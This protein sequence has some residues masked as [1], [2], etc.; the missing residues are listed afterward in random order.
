M[1]C[2]RA[3][4]VA[5]PST[6][7]GCVIMRRPRSYILSVTL[8]LIVFAGIGGAEPKERKERARQLSFKVVAVYPHDY[9]AFTEGLE[10]RDGFLLESTGLMGES[11]LR[12]VDLTTG[13]VVSKIALEPHLFGEGCTALRD[14][15][16]LVTWRNRIG[17]VYDF[18][19]WNIVR[20]FS[21]QGEG[22][23]LAND[24]RRIFMSDGTSV[25]RLVDPGSLDVIGEVAV[26]D[27]TEPI[28]HLNELEF[29]DGQILANVWPTDQI[30]RIDPDSG[31]VT[32]RIDLRGII[33]KTDRV[34]VANGIAFDSIKRRLFVTGQRWNRVF[35]IS[36]D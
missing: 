3:A 31:E 11:S 33:E 13:H 18:A 25:L 19:T 2:L 24:G 6:L 9:T 32:G 16:F 21:Y 27:G 29:V 26:H 15:L 17:F 7:D 20:R 10:Y 34:G 12:K 14:R 35:Q 5:W 23:G 8:L 30:V 1:S 4:V 36:L 22:W 28:E